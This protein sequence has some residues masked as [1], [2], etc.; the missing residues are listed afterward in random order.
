MIRRSWVAVG[1]VL[2]LLLAFPVSADDG[3]GAYVPDRIKDQLQQVKEQIAEAQKAGRATEVRRL[4]AKAKKIAQEGEQ[5]ARRVQQLITEKKIKDDLDMLLLYR[6]HKEPIVHEIMQYLEALNLINGLNL[7]D[8]QMKKML[9]ILRKKRKLL[10]DDDW[11]KVIRGY[12]VVKEGLENDPTLDQ[13]TEDTFFLSE[14]LFMQLTAEDEKRPKIIES[15][16]KDVEKVLTDSQKEVIRT[17]VPCHI[18]PREM[19]DPVRVGQAGVTSEAVRGLWDARN[20]PE[21]ELDEWFEGVVMPF[22][23]GKIESYNQHEEYAGTL[24]ERSERKRLMKLIKKVRAMSDVEFQMKKKELAA[25][26]QLGP[27]P[28]MPAVD[29]D[30]LKRRIEHFLLD[31]RFI[32]L[33]EKRLAKVATQ[34]K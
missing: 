1:L 6:S 19:R 29:K 10:R 34:T 12:L 13:A 2:T 26:V 17:F 14:P 11:Q 4:V 20:V 27:D 31:E 28:P 15:L 5:R 22:I 9:A 23:R 3:R 24:S 16:R 18:P 21:D 25:Q 33:Y 30:E 8:A 7:T 32:P